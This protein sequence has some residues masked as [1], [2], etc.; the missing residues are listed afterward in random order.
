ME[1]FVWGRG[2]KEEAAVIIFLMIIRMP[3]ERALLLRAPFTFLAKPFFSLDQKNTL[4]GK[5]GS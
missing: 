5:R 1:R 4:T 3:E 2:F